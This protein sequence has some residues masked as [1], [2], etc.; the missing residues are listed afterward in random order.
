[1]MTKS[2]E[3]RRIIG[4]RIARVLLRPFKTDNAGCPAEATYDPRIEFTDGTAM[5]FSVDE[6]E[7]GEYGVV[8][9]LTKTKR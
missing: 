1:M 8:P 9:H 2:Q 6:T 3:M 4:K 7:T 5:Y